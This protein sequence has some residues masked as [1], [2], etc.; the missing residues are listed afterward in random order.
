MLKCVSNKRRNESGIM[1]DENSA[2]ENWIEIF[3]NKMRVFVLQIRSQLLKS[4]ISFGSYYI[5]NSSRY[6]SPNTR[7]KLSF[8]TYKVDLII[9]KMLNI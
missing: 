9:F 2:K 6:R 5:T 7:K 1:K 8:I 4:N 3:R